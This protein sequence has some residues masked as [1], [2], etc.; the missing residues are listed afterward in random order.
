MTRDPTSTKVFISYSSR[1]RQ[2]AF[3]LRTLLEARG[4]DVWLDYFDIKP[5]E[6]LDAELAAH[7]QRADVVCLLLSPTAVASKWVNIEIEHARTQ[8]V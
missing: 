2:S 5:A 8:Q 6:Q 1:D 3:A 4:C 7:V